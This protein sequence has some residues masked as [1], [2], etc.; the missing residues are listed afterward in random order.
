MHLISFVEVPPRTF[1]VC[2]DVSSFNNTWSPGNVPTTSE[3]VRAGTVVEP[4]SSMRA[5]IQHVMPIS[6]FVA[7]RRKRPSSEAINMLASTGS[8]LRG[9]TALETIPRPRARFSCRTVTLMTYLLDHTN[10]CS[11]ILHH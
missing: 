4:S 2:V 5:A 3:K 1:S 11:T 8:V 10:D 9:E 6:R 7:E